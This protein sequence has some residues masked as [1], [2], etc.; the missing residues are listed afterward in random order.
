[1]TS[2]SSSSYPSTNNVEIDFYHTTIKNSKGAVE[3]Y[4]ASINSNISKFPTLPADGF[5]VIYDLYA[6]GDIILNNEQPDYLKHIAKYLLLFWKSRGYDIKV[7]FENK[8]N[9]I[10]LH[11][12]C[13]I[14]KKFESFNEETWFVADTA[15]TIE[16]DLFI[17]TPRPELNYA[18]TVR[19][20]NNVLS[21]LYID[22]EHKVPLIMS[23]YARNLLHNHI[24]SQK[25]LDDISGI[26]F[27]SDSEDSGD[28]NTVDD[29][30]E[31]VLPDRP[32]STTKIQL[33]YKHANAFPFKETQHPYD[34][35]LA[36]KLRKWKKSEIAGFQNISAK[37][38]EN[39]ANPLKEI[40]V[41]YYQSE[42]LANLSNRV[43]AFDDIECKD[44]KP[45]LSVFCI[46][47]EIN[48]LKIR[49]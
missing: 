32:A 25:L 35:K 49:D 23:L 1:M 12:D 47:P 10:V 11:L 46:D 42:S 16:I 36:K 44:Y 8:S 15:N 37:F 3:T 6:N 18:W 33:T 41:K 22:L 26:I 30:D 29:D 39:Q 31:D 34:E 27:E 2:T 17:F 48:G 20:L 21:C 24:T 28:E 4:V 9:S 38:I 43:T 13:K 7:D 5:K 19:P 14:L 45:C 40:S